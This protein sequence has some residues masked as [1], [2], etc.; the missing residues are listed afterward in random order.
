MNFDF[1]PDQTELRAQL[2][3][4]L[5]EEL[6]RGWVGIWHG[7]DGAPTSAKVT[8]EMGRRGWLT[9]YWPEEFGGKGGSVW[10]Q[11]VIQ[12]ELFARHEPRGAQYMGVN[13]IGPALM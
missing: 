5:N 2:R 4:F 12:E 6:P 7:P 3:Q 10:D 8:A 1:S 13:W 11:T 9:Y